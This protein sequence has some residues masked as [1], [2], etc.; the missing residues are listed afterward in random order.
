MDKKINILKIIFPS[1]LVMGFLLTACYDDFHGHYHYY[2]DLAS[3]YG[4]VQTNT[5]DASFVI[6]LDNGSVVTPANAPLTGFTP[7][8]SDRVW[9]RFNPVSDTHITD[10]TFNYVAKIYNIHDILFK[11]IKKLSDVSEDSVG[12]DPIIVKSA[13]IAP[14]DILN[15]ELKFFTAGSVHYIN[16]LDNGEGNGVSNPYILELR[17][18]ARGDMKEFP[19]YA[20]VSFKLNNLRVSGQ[21]QVQFF[22]RYTDYNGN[23]IDIPKT[24]YY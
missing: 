16:L 13:W 6:N 18:N 15:L 14:A 22:I 23:R 1:V 17:H 20:T 11:D 5:T 8:D 4:L 24:Y 3:S 9:V 7:K 21:N 10:S 19:V 2:D 12:H